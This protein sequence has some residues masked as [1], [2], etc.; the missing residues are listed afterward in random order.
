VGISEVRAGGLE[1]ILVPRSGPL[2]ASC[3][4]VGVRI[5]GDRLA[6]KP[7]GT[8]A[9][10]DRGNPLAA[11][12]CGES[13]RLGARR[14]TVDVQ[15]GPFRVDIL[16]LESPAPSPVGAPARGGGRVVG[17]GEAG[18][19][20]YEGVQVAL[21]GPSWL[22]LSESFNG[23]WRAS[24]DGRSL[25]APTVVDGFANGWHA[26]AGCRS[27]DFA[28]APTAV[29]HVSYWISG[30]A[31]LGMTVVLLAAALRRRG[32]G[33]MPHTTHSRRSEVAAH[34]WPLRRALVTGA[35]LALP[36]ALLFS[37]RAGVVIGPALALMLWRGAGVR[38][39]ALGA[40]ALLGVMVP[41][42][43]LSLLPDDLG[44]F[45]SEYPLDLIAVHW[46]AVG[47]WVLLAVALWRSLAGPGSDAAGLS[48]A[49]R[50]SG[51]RA[52]GPAAAA[53]PPARP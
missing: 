3:G 8:V 48:R 14:A 15:P 50:P 27:V 28:F 4:A 47:A 44:G 40:G 41:A 23:G 18:R 45:N 30:L 46:L 42:V 35:L 21:D 49:S 22:V 17:T 26:P 32:R 39:L 36:A 38:S 37:L 53:L 29:A 25:G 19:G 34:R 24:C 11:A 1:R 5:S 6:M 51:G 52:A 43:Q 12:P 16:R 7:T 20:S 2:R 10:L 33:A 9:D 31:C 13:A